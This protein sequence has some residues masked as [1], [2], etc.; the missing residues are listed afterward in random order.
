MKVGIETPYTPTACSFLA[1]RLA[2]YLQ[3]EGLLGPFLTKG[4]KVD[5]DGVWDKKT[6]YSDWDV[7]LANLLSCS[8]FVW[9]DVPNKFQLMIAEK[10]KVKRV[11]LCGLTQ[12]TP[13]V[14]PNLANADSIMTTS[15]R[16]CQLLRTTFNIKK[17]SYAPAEYGLTYLKKNK[18]YNHGAVS[19]AIPIEGW[20]I[21]YIVRD[22]LKLIAAVIDRFDNVGFTVILH[23]SMP[24]N[25]KQELHKLT[26][27]YPDRIK[28]VKP[29]T[30]NGLILEYSRCDLTVWLARSSD[31]GFPA[32]CSLIAG[33]PLIAYDI[34]PI[35]EIATT[36]H[37]SILVPVSKHT[38]CMGIERVANEANNVSALTNATIKMLSQRNFLKKLRAGTD[39]HAN[40]KKAL[41][42]TMWKEALDLH[43]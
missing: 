7:W 31:F 42:E 30:L 4:K 14:I 16:S 29:T 24:P 17:V 35:D 23:R 25:L 5:F 21:N 37:N 10:L 38:N 41:F 11:V 15:W 40:D 2:D 28:V 6:Q 18:V 9:T 36:G 13:E 34:P 12:L 27:K 39:K 26:T 3:D 32:D 22:S 19:L 1:T 20:P 8:S 43:R 33:T